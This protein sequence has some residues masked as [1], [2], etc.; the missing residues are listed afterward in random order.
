M[1][2]AEAKVQQK[3][4]WA[5]KWK[6][7]QVKMLRPPFKYLFIL[8]HMRSGSTLLVH[9]LN[10][11]PDIAGYGESIVKYQSRADL[12]A[13]VL[14]VAQFFKKERL[15]QQFIMDKLMQDELLP[16]RTLLHEPDIYSLFLLRQPEE[17]LPS[18]LDIYENKFPEIAPALAGGERE[19]VNY[20]IQRLDTMES[21]ARQIDSREKAFMLTYDDL[22]DRTQDVFDNMQDWLGVKQPFSEAYETHH[23]TGQLVTGDWTETIK[24]GRIVRNEKHEYKP[25]SAESMAR[26]RKAYD[27]CCSSL[28]RYCRSAQGQT[29]CEQPVNA[30]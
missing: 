26:A 2:T 16:N 4:S 27:S 29:A 1:A 15:P 17:A 8:G 6:A 22:K 20:Y 25:V 14:K 19:A 10:S 9:I 28:R 23:A 3:D 5:R 13:L 30:P 21:Y 12:D 24:T 7:M 11:N 18:I